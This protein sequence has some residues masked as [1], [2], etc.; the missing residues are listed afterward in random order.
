MMIS[1]PMKALCSCFFFFKSKGSA[2]VQSKNSLENSKHKTE[3]EQW[4]TGIKELSK[5][6]SSINVMEYISG[7]PLIPVHN[8][9]NRNNKRNRR[10]E[11]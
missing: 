10:E 1:W 7:K 8:N 11:T 5:T 6:A 9:K 4:S 2:K 3:P